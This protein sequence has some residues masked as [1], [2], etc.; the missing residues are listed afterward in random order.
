MTDLTITR[1]TTAAG[2][3]LHVAG[4]LDYAEAPLLRH[5]VEGLTLPRDGCLTI[6]LSRTELCDSSGLTVLL[7]ALRHAEAAGAA[8]VLAGVPPRLQRTLAVTGLDRVFT[9]HPPAGSSVA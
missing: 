8:L 9:L 4:A 6:D 1:Q 7:V 2:P 3:V 5:E